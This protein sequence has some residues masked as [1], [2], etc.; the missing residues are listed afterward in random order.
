MPTL[1]KQLHSTQPTWCDADGN[2]VGSSSGAYPC[3]EPDAYWRLRAV[4]ADGNIET[5]LRCNKCANCLQFNR[6][7]EAR[8]LQAHYA[9][10]EM[11][12]GTWLKCTEEETNAV[13]RGCSHDGFYRR[14]STSI[15][16]LSSAPLALPRG[17]KKRVQREWRM[18]H[19]L[20]KWKRLLVGLLRPRNAEW[21]K[22]SNR[23][24][25]RGLAPAE[26]EPCAIVRGGI[27][28][29]HP[30]FGGGRD[31]RAVRR[32][33][34]GELLG[35]NRSARRIRRLAPESAPLVRP[36]ILRIEHEP[37]LAGALVN[38][39]FSSLSAAAEG[40]SEVSIAAKPP[41]PPRSQPTKYESPPPHSY[42]GGYRTSL[43]SLEATKA[44]IFAACE[45][46][47]QKA[48]ERGS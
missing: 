2:V 34:G 28:K 19:Q 33:A 47:S 1:A 13:L 4:T 45:R 37:Q 3:I 5:A 42:G 40:R 41:P 46:M 26:K 9:N 38:K 32:V 31:L 15:N 8:R 17:L 36:E 27:T 10:R 43:Q 24:Y 30:E 20:R 23:F 29:A 39:L 7:R 16:V 21:R 6:D 35:L 14:D 11:P 44:E 25:V 22:N 48:R 12:Y 18:R